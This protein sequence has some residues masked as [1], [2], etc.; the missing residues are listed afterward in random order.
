MQG[1]FNGPRLMVKMFINAAMYILGT[2]SLTIKKIL[3]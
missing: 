1:F 3:N 2:I